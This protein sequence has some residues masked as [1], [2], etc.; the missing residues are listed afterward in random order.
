METFTP[1]VVKPPANIEIPDLNEVWRS[2][3]LLFFLVR[4]DLKIRFQQ[5]FI[6]VLWIVLQPL[7]Q[8]S[9]FFVILGLF[10]KV[11]TDGIPYPVFYLS[12]FIVWQLFLQIVNSSAYSLL[13]NIGLITKAYFP[14]MALP[15]STTI[16]A[17]IDFG[18][19]FLLLLVFLLSNHFM[20]NLRY[21][22]LPVLL[23]IT[24]VFSLGVGLLFGALMV[25][26][27]DTKNL[28]GFI[29]Q[30]W[31]FASPIMYPLSIVPEKY[32]FLFYLNPLAG[33]IDAFRWVFLKT[34]SLPS[35]LYFSLSIIVAVILLIV[36]MIAFRSMENRIADV[37]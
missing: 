2:K 20:P 36:G 11:P 31:M 7:I 37:M 3:D 25:V 18:V 23:L 32:K 21:L 16:G 13:G 9:I 4:R 10:V 26:F 27:R 1:I 35:L 34:D 15:L 29:L 17:L 19:S 33:L 28:L 8:M 24:L 22:L 6:G 12:G 30:V 14:R 5:T